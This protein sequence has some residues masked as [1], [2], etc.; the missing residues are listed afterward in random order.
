MTSPSAPRVLVFDVNETL[1]D[2]TPMGER[3]ADL[4]VD[5]LLAKVWFASVLRDGFALSTVGA[6]E[7]FATIAGSALKAVTAGRELDRS[8]D[9]AVQHVLSGFMA[10][11]VHPDVPAGLRALAEAGYRLVTLSNGSAAVAET[12]LSSAG[13]REHVEKVLTVEDAGIW[14]PAPASYA[15]AAQQCGVELGEMMMVAVHAWDTDGAAR[16]GMQTAY[17]NRTGGEYPTYFTPPTVTATG[18][19]DL[20][21]RLAR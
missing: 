4:G 10:L 7:K 8:A 17:I 15:H 1:S 18:I 13:L 6:S 9:D 12:L 16:A 21:R 19:D 11:Q 20:A 5:P 3:F 2:L 14:K